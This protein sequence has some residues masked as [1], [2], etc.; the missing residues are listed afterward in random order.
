MVFW[1]MA[2]QNWACKESLLSIDS[3]GHSLG[4][5]MFEAIKYPRSMMVL[6]PL[7]AVLGWAAPHFASLSLK[8]TLILGKINST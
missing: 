1:H 5:H 6:S 3:V 7:R 8:A 4:L 2:V